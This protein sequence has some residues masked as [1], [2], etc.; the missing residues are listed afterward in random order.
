MSRAWPW[1]LVGTCLLII[2]TEWA[3][4]Y[5][6][7]D[8]LLPQ[9]FDWRNARKA[10]SGLAKQADLLCFG[11]SLIKT[12]V[13]PPVVEGRIG[14]PTYCLA[15]GAGT[16]PTSYFL[17]RRALRSGARP[18][19]VL[20]DAAPHILRDG[21][22]SPGAQAQWAELLNLP[23]QFDLAA[24]AREPQLF[25]RLVLFRCLQTLRYRQEIRAAVLKLVR[26][27]RVSN[28]FQVAQYLRNS[29][30]NLG[31]N[32]FEQDAPTLL[33]TPFALSVMFDRFGCRALAASYLER[34]LHLAESHQIAVFLVLPPP[35]SGAQVH[36]ENTG[37]DSAHTAFVRS[38][39]ARH[40]SLMV[41]DGRQSEYPQSRYYRDPVHLSH[42]AATVFSEDAADI[43]SHALASPAE[44]PRWLKM[45]RYRPRP[46]ALPVEDLSA[47]ALAI[48]APGKT[49]R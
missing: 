14:R 38:L 45:P 28:R 22:D 40:P 49:R 10:A 5:V 9:H 42:V 11:D 29:R 24:T 47:S 30:V 16:T 23:E 15:V 44:S 25:G 27:E 13:L 34:F 48:T 41:I 26:G 21:L 2:V 3:F 20:L 1:G 46:P 35:S 37:Y 4:K 7:A 31:A 39:Q 6:E 12:A 18:S 19:A 36:A 17:F 43:V 33:E 32:A 8:V